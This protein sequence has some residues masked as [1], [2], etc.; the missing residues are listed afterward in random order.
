MRSMRVFLIF[1][2]AAAIVNGVDAQGRRRSRSGGEGIAEGKPA[3]EF[4]LQRTDRSGM[5]TL[6]DLRDRPV[7]LIFGSYT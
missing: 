3:L 2:A 6:K 1:L 7:V 5:V 4:S